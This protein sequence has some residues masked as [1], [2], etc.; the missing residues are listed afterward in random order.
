MGVGTV[1]APGVGCGAGG[2]GAGVDG[3]VLK[4]GARFKLRVIVRFGSG[5]GAEAGVT[6][7][8]RDLVL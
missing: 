6:Y 8:F 5:R 7:F 3:F 2:I 1:I 4:L